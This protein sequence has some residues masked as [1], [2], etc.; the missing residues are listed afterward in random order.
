MEFGGNLGNFKVWGGS[1]LRG[2]GQFGGW[3]KGR[4]VG[5]MLGRIEGLNGRIGQAGW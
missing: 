3:K 5:I 1:N 2:L 4:S